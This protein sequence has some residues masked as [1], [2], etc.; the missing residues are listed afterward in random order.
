MTFEDQAARDVEAA[1]TDT[2]AI[3]KVVPGDDEPAVGKLRDNRLCLVAAGLKMVDLN[4]GAPDYR[5]HDFLLKSATARGWV[6]TVSE[7]AGRNARLAIADGRASATARAC[8]R[9]VLLSS[10]RPLAAA[11]FLL[12]LR[13]ARVAE[14]E[15]AGVGGA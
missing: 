15:P 12:C 13:G 6:G 7:F 5:R 1:F 2:S 3:V 14:L 4:L 10:W 9:D 8:C 11:R